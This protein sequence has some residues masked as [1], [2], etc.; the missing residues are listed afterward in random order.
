MYHKENMYTGF[1][2]PANKLQKSAFST[3]A[4]PCKVYDVFEKDFNK[5]LLGSFET[6]NAAADFLDIKTSHIF[7]IIKNKSRSKNERLGKVITVR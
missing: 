2:M 5:K 6:L 4:T 7:S 3:L 1:N